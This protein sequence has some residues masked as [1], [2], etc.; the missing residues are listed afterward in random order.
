MRK[1]PKKNVD[2]PALPGVNK[3]PGWLNW[4]AQWR[5]LLITLLAFLLAGYEIYDFTHAQNNLIKEFEALIFF[6]LLFA[7]G[8]LLII[9]SRRIRN[10]TRIIRILG[11]KHRLSLEFSR[12]QD[13]EVLVNHIAKLPGSLAP[14][15]EACLFVSN[16]ITNQFSLA[17]QWNKDPDNNVDPCI[18]EICAECTGYGASKDL[19]FTRC[20]SSSPSG[21]EYSQGKK[22]CLPV[23]DERR[24]LGILQFVLEPAK[25][26]TD[27]QIDIFSNI[28]DDIA[29]ALKAG[30]D[31]KLLS[32]LRTS[33]TALAERRS[34]SH[35][36][37]D[38]LGQN[39]GYLHLKM[40]QLLTERDELSLEKVLIDLE[41]MRNAA[42]ESYEIVRG[43]LET[44]HPETAHTL[45]NLMMEHARKISK[46][47]NI[48]IEFKTKGKPVFFPE[49]TQQAIFYAFEEAISNVEKHAR[50]TRVTVL[51]EWR[52]EQF[53]LIVSD[54][55]VG[56]NPQYVDT[57]QHFGLEILNERMS[58]VNGQITL[59]TTEKS[60][61]VVK[62]MIPKEP[63]NWKGAE[64]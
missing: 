37:H 64:L 2:P 52:I 16:D 44:I 3:I 42:H 57:D 4:V 5:W 46:R 23:M 32:D 47:S 29:V 43:V 13:W 39:L 22:Y 12:Y 51:A 28:G 54:N 60:G 1:K 26:L 34:V 55:G 30:Q 31:R 9:L 8:F 61:T 59:Q 24:L 19:T 50:A 49:E 45:T 56:F 58:K 41:L 6:G 15:S 27:E 11:A 36:L 53:S 14:A 10:Q 25:D 38:H 40:D 35:Y 17:A 48:N 7:V 62:I 33:E 20:R 63:D 18:E 21:D